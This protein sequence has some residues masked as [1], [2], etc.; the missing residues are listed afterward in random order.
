MNFPYR[1]SGVLTNAWQ[2][3]RG[4]PQERGQ[5]ASSRKLAGSRI[6]VVEDEFIIALEIQS[7]LEEAGA[8]VIGPAFTLAKAFDLAMREKLCAATLDLRLGHDSIAPVA[9][10][11]N[12]RHVPFLF[13]T[14]QP[15]DDPVRR[16]WSASKT[17]SKP[18]S[19]DTLVEAVAEI[20][21]TTH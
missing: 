14:G 19:G 16:A 2:Q 13:Y 18:A 11:L 5:R 10:L 7:N 1:A 4:T 8:T 12:E 20:I 17:L 21:R 9:R 6:L 3:F 15:V